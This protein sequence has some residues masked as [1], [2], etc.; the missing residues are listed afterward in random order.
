MASYLP[1]VSPLVSIGFCHPFPSETHC[2]SHL[3]LSVNFSPLPGKRGQSPQNAS[4]SQT[5]HRGHVV[6]GLWTETGGTQK[7][8]KALALRSPAAPGLAPVPLPSLCPPTVWP[9][10]LQSRPAQ[11]PVRW[12]CCY[13]CPN[14]AESPAMPPHG[15]VPAVWPWCPSLSGL[16]VLVAEMGSMSVMSGRREAGAAE[17]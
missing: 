8:S 7:R 1:S 3:H 15:P 17:A 16:S 2:V 5:Q 9:P 14:R 10:V 4:R 11:V 12:P 13:H 6:R